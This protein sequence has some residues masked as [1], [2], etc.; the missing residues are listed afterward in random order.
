MVFEGEIIHIVMFCGKTG[1]C[2]TN[3][4]QR[5]INKV[6]GRFLNPNPTNTRTHLSQGLAQLSVQL[7]R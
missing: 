6:I 5:S 4:V 1:K 2:R 7:N 3:I